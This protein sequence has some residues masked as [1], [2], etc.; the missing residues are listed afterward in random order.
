M[1]AIEV[2][3]VSGLAA[4][5][6]RILYNILQQ[7]QHQSQLERAFYKLLESQDG[8]ISLIQLAA[9]ARVNG[10]LAKEYLE[11][12]AIM[13]EAITEV[14]LNSGTFYRFPKLRSPSK[15]NFN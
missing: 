10:Q 1:V 13:F 8:C 6:G 14:D 7:R 4:I 2:V 12:Q 5:A 9:A 11:E 15:N 3:L